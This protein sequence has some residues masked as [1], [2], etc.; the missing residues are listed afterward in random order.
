MLNNYQSSSNVNTIGQAIMEGSLGIYKGAIYEN[1]IA[2]AL[3]KNGKNL[4][5]FTRSTGLEIDFVTTYK[6][7]V[8]AIEVKA[9]DGR[10]KS[11][12]EVLTNKAKYDVISNYKLVDGN[13]NKGDLI[14]R[15]PLYMAYLIK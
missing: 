10:A 7:E 12:K 1:L 9:T 5:Y 3:I 8:T 11:L 6:D 14:N 2:D 13:V 15:I 4:Y